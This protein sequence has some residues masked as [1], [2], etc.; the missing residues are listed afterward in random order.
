M[1]RE[2][3]DWRK[4]GP[5]LEDLSTPY[6]CGVCGEG[7]CKLWRSPGFNDGSPLRCVRCACESTGVDVAEIDRYGTRKDEIVPGDDLTVD[8][9]GHYVPAI[10]FDDGSRYR[11]YTNVPAEELVWWSMLPTCP[12][13]IDAEYVV[14]PEQRQLA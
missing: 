14:V 13:V 11:S 10:P 3:V 9:I 4:L 5:K 12:R 8:T 7:G 1:S 2:A 6:V